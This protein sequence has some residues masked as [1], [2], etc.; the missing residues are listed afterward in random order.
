MSPPDLR[1]RPRLEVRDISVAYPGKIVVR[2]AG[3]RLEQGRIGC[4]LGPSGCGKT[5]LLRAIAGFEPVIDGEI[6]LR[7]ECV[8]R[9]GLSVPP[10]R[11]GVGM[12]FQDFALFPH[13]SVLENIGFGIRNRPRR[14][15]RRRIPELLEV[16]GLGAF[17]HLYPHQLSGGQQQ[18]VALA[19]ALAP[20][21]QILLLDEPFSSMDVDLR[22]QLASE[23]REVLKREDM[24]AILVT[25]DQHEAFAMADETGVMKNGRIVQWDTAY[26][27]Y[28]RPV[29]RFVADF[30]GLRTLLRG[31]VIGEHEVETTLGVLNGE[32][33]PG[34]A[35]GEPVGLLVR[36]DDVVHNDA[37]LL[38]AKVE[39]WQFRGAKFLYHLRLANGERILCFA[40]SHHNHEIGEAI[41]IE[42][43]LE[44]L[45]MFKQDHTMAALE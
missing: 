5:T 11:R 27:L 12:V 32:I 20:R 13:L 18:R 23:V 33:A 24:T 7:G 34:F 39:A 21:P 16:V 10:E 1:M 29:N 6:R 42:V 8:S 19:R 25:H 26:N 2:E 15:R 31:T 28:H 38:K 17:E 9:R 4:L 44:H 40:P 14:E 43:D 41:G 45:V 3:F 36:P 35:P 37:S 30:I 22:E